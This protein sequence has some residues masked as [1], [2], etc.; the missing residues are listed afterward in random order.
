MP[1][2]STK[3]RVLTPWL[4][5]QMWHRIRPKHDVHSIS[6]WAGQMLHKCWQQ[7]LSAAAEL[8][9]V[10][11][12]QQFLALALGEP[13]A[14]DGDAGGRMSL[15]VLDARGGVRAATLCV[16]GPASRGAGCGAL[17]CFAAPPPCRSDLRSADG[18]RP[19]T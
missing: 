11:G 4:C 1:K 14:P 5:K 15:A 2:C 17:G 9:G 3:F 6:L 7:A 19:S 16:T 18:V 8:P 13:E 12:G 10:L